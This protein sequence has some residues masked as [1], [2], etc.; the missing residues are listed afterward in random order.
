MADAVTQMPVPPAGDSA[1]WAR[2]SEGAGMRYVVVTAKHH[3]GYCL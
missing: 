3:E 2:M 1:A